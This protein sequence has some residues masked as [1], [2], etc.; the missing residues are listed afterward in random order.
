MIALTNRSIL[1]HSLEIKLWYATKE[2]K[3]GGGSCEALKKKESRVVAYD[4]FLAV[5]WKNEKN[6]EKRFL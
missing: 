6:K 4:F 2:R 5:W 3:G 1:L